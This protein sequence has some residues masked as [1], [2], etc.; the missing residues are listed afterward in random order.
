MSR[1]A[2]NK[3]KGDD[4]LFAAEQGGQQEC[5]EDKRSKQAPAATVA[6]AASSSSAAANDSGSA[7]AM[8]GRRGRRA[9]SAAASAAA[10]QPRGE[11]EEVVC[12]ACHEPFEGADD[13][14]RLP[15][16]LPCG[17]PLCSACCK[18]SL[19]L[20]PGSVLCPH[21]HGQIKIS[22]PD[23]VAAAAISTVEG[24]LRLLPPRSDL[25]TAIRN[26]AS[27]MTRLGGQGA[28]CSHSGCDAAVTHY[29]PDCGDL[30]SAHERIHH[31]LLFESHKAATVPIAQKAR[32]LQ[33]MFA[34][35][36]AKIRAQTR[37]AVAQQQSR[38]TLAEAELKRLELQVEQKRRQVQA[39]KQKLAWIKQTANRMA[40]ANDSA[41]FV[42]EAARLE[43][44]AQARISTRGALNDSAAQ[45]LRDSQ[46]PR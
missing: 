43:A 27:L 35:P 25:I 12:S 24:W 4:E 34:G 1:R 41:V 23:G 10:S 30:C 18:Q 6:A 17:H 15:R 26:Q 11:V 29:C 22:I 3:R 7:H 31:S 46:H 42:L 44:A 2:A 32:A 20:T 16:T 9:A 38:L 5:K 21:E 39:R 36:A 33:R 28:R 40:A 45:R 8:T 37:E 19:T 14:A 13:S